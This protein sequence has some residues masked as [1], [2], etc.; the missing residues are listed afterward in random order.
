MA[1][2]TATKRRRSTKKVSV[3]NTLADLNSK[4]I[5]SSEELIDNTIVT[6]EKYQKLFAKSLKKTEPIVEKQ[7]DIMFD[8]LESLKEQFDFGTV[9]FKKLIGWNGKTLKTFRKNAEKNIKSIR[10]TAEDRIESIQN[11][12]NIGTKETVEAPK[13]AKTL[14][15]KVRTVAKNVKAVKVTAKKVTPKKVVAKKVATT[16]NITGLQIIDGIGPKMEQ[17]LQAGGIKTVNGLAKASVAKLEK[18]IEQSGSNFRAINTK[19]WIA[20]ASKIAK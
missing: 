3:K 19:S 1:T 5:N 14:T 12:L 10:K 9:R 15:R 7:V 4:L 17:V 20:Q 11:D 8:T 2:A 13:V 6:G 16:K 18:V